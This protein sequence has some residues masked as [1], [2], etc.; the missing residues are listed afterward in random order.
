MG[1]LTVERE[2][3][4]PVPHAHLHSIFAPENHHLHLPKIVPH[5]HVEILEGNGG[6]GT[7][8]RVTFDAPADNIFKYMKTITEETN[9]NILRYSII[10]AEP[11][12]DKLEKMT[13]EV[14]VKASINGGSII[15][16]STEYIPKPN[17]ELD[18]DEVN[19]HAEKV[20]GL[21]KVLEGHV[22]TN[23]NA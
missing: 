15:K 4:M 14:T 6:P 7:I 17:C 12:S 9:G 1:V 22:L 5:F 16:H 2:I 23:L 13:V 20:V 10:E 19:A 8:K 18:E 3:S 21:Y 11:W